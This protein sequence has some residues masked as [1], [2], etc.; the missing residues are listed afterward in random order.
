[1]TELERL[2]RDR[3]GKV[4]VRVLFVRP[5]GLLD[6]P[7]R[8]SL[9]ERVAGIPGARAEIDEGGVTA[10]LPAILITR[11]LFRDEAVGVPARS[12]GAIGC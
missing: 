8:S 2:M 10:G 5:Q 12:R 4:D 1:V 3:A 11:P 7:A 6:D 9:W